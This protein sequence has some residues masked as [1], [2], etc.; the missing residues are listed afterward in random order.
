[1]ISAWFWYDPFDVGCRDDSQ[2][3]MGVGMQELDHFISHS[4]SVDGNHRS[5]CDAS[6]HPNRKTSNSGV[7]KQLSK[8]CQETRCQSLMLE[9]GG[10]KKTVLKVLK[11]AASKKLT[12]KCQ[13]VAEKN[14][15][16]DA[17]N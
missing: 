10:P 4:V 7:I 12:G 1:M 2:K 14:L 3:K 5:I 11:A 6:R 17:H 8:S 9:D 15:L 13:Y 16:G